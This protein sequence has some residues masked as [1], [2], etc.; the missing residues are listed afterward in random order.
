MS[1][2]GEIE[3]EREMDIITDYNWKEFLAVMKRQR[4]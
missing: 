3:I 1:V 2:D 4:V